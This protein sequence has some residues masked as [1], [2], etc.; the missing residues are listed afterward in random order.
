MSAAPVD[1]DSISEPEPTREEAKAIL[2]KYLPEV[3]GSLRDLDGI[4]KGRDLDQARRILEVACRTSFDPE[5]FHIAAF[6]ADRIAKLRNGADVSRIYGTPNTDENRET[7]A[8]Y[9]Q[10]DLNNLIRELTQRI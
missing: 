8:E 7:W 6:T 5:T 1:L 4:T 3:F 10:Q 9:E 2:A